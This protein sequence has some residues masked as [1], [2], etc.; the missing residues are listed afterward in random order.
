[1]YVEHKRLWAFA[2]G[3]ALFG[4]ALG[5]GVFRVIAGGG[6]K[7]VSGN[8]LSPV[9]PLRA[10]SQGEPAPAITEELGRLRAEIKTLQERFEAL[11]KRVTNAPMLQ[12]PSE[13]EPQ[14]EAEKPTLPRTTIADSAL[15]QRDRQAKL[16]AIEQAFQHQ[17]LATKWGSAANAAIEQAFET[18]NQTTGGAEFA[19]SEM[20]SVDCRETLCRLEITHADMD[21]VRRFI[22][23]FPRS[24]GP[25]LPR[26]TL[27][28]SQNPDGSID[29]VVYLAKEG[30]RFPQP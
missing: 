14:E 18:L 11:P 2:L 7:P 21:S 16:D 28:P 25:G 3:G 5:Y 13:P 23:D 8:E 6:S 24:V 12:A 20:T 26:M 9:M 22:E 1:M 17:P 10:E 30:S 27:E 4:V 29:T 19:G 15:A